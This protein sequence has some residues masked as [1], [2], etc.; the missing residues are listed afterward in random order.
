MEKN[1]PGKAIYF[2]RAIIPHGVTSFYLHVGIYA[3][4]Y[5]AITKFV[6]LPQSFLEKSE[7]LEQLRAI[8]NG[9]NV[10]AVPVNGTFISVDVE[11]D[12]IKVLK[13]LGTTD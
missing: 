9:M 12:L 1:A 4:R 3:Y 10:W 6:S 11:D 13:F 8:Q 5:S 2:S 7:K